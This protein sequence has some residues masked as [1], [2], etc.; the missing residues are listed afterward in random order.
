MNVCVM[1]DLTE[2]FR[3]R[4]NSFRGGGGSGNGDGKKRKCSTASSP[5]TGGS[6]GGG[7]AHIAAGI[8][9]SIGGGS[10]SGGNCS[11]VHED[12]NKS[13]PGSRRNSSLS[14]TRTSS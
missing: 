10:S 5:G 4:S 12:F 2:L 8:G 1:F 7:D 14:S 9:I 3:G 6:G 11:S 13:N